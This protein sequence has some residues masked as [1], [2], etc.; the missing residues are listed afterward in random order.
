MPA[1]EQLLHVLPAL[2]V[3]GAGRVGVGQLVH[4]QQGGVPRDARRRGRTPRAGCRGTRRVR[5]GSVSRPSSRRGGL[6]APVGLHHPDHHV[7]AL[8][9]LGARGLQHGE[10]LPHAGG[11]AEE[12]LELAAA[13][14]GLLV[15]DPPE[16]SVGIGARS[17]SCALKLRADGAVRQSR[18][19]SA[20]LSSSTLT[21]GS[22]RN[23]NCR[24]SVCRATSSRTALGRHAARA[25]HA[26][27]LQLGVGRRDVRVE[28]GAGGGHHVGR[29][30]PPLGPV[31][32]RP[33][34]ATAPA[35]S[36]SASFRSVGPL[37]VP[38]EAA[39]S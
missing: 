37:L 32:L 8:G 2:G 38:A 22:P 15:L 36:V 33:P 4:Q 13:G 24:P 17:G 31:L 5:R 12:D 23:P 39:A 29:D 18:L 10:G 9:P 30:P 35:I 6:R 14:P 7:E 28:P 20:M 19:S 21:R 11:G 27:H 1:V 26:R 16:E 25:G 34:A 3:A